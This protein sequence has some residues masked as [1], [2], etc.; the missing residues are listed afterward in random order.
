M[1]RLDPCC[2]AIRKLTLETSRS[3]P[4][5]IS[6]HANTS[7]ARVKQRLDSGAGMSFAEFTYPVMQAWDWWRLYESLGVQMQIGG[8]DQYG[9]IEPE[10][11]LRK[12]GGP[13]NEPVGFTVPLLTD[14]AGAKFGKSAGNA[15][16]L[17]QYMTGA[18]DLNGNFVRRPDDELE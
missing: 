15:L 11:G 4:Q 3:S 18:F 6:A 7:A 2:R 13:M 5:H 14:S 10:P 16:W 17:D 8:S 1:R 9:D 12:P